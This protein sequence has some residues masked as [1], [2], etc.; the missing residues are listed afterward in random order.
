MIAQGILVHKMSTSTKKSAI[1]ATN[2]AGFGKTEIQANKMA[3]GRTV[4]HQY[5]RSVVNKADGP[6]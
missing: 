6:G 1:E 2:K 5:S 3:F 4:P